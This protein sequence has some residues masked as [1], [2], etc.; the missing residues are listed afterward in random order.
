MEA[1]LDMMASGALDVAPLISHRFAFDDALEA[2]EL[3]GGG[4]ASLGI[5]LEYS[6]GIVLR[7]REQLT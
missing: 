7:L 5:L 4:A 6:G 2:F 1:V 3:L